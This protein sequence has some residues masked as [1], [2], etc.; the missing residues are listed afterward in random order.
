V[1]VQIKFEHEVDP[2]NVHVFVK[3]K[4]LDLEYVHVDCPGPRD[5]FEMFRIAALHLFRT[6]DPEKT[7]LKIEDNSIKVFF[8]MF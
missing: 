1:T 4:S 7:Q 3:A 2:R 6:V 5:S 8:T